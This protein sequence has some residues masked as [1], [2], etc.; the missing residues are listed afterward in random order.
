MNAP[1]LLIGAARSSSGKTTL[2]LGLMRALTRRG[3][4]VAPVKCGPDYID[5]AFHAAATGRPGVNLDSW[6]MDANL[7]A[8]LAARVSEGADIVIAEGAMGL[9]D[10][11]PGGAAG[12]GASADIA[13]LLGWSVVLVHDVSGQG[14]TA[15]A[16][17]RGIAGHDARVKVAGVVLNRVGSERHRRLAGEAIE[18]LDIPVFGALPRNEKMALPER[19]LGLVQ[20]GETPG[21]DDRLDALADFVEAHVD[22]EAIV[23]CG[24]IAASS[25]VIPDASRKRS[26]RESSVTPDAS[27]AAPDSRSPAAR[28][29]GMTGVVA[30]PPP[31]QRIAVARDDAFSFFYPHLA[32]SWRDAGA[33]L[34]FF[35]PLADEAPPEDCDLCWLPG[36]YPELHAG[37]L[38]AARGFK[39][40]LRR[41]AQRGWLHGECGGYMVLGRA[42]IDAA[43]AAHEMAGLLELETSFAKR[44]LHLG[45]RQARL[46][47]DHPLGAVGL[48]LRGHEFHYATVLREEGAPFALARDAYSEDERPAGLARNGVSGSFFHLLA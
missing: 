41:F 31:A 27:V 30:T 20:A 6:A 39:N 18:A 11:A 47:V 24:T 9:F 34:R 32:Q 2:T 38:S 42:L 8:R 46:A 4:R 10:G 15:A 40:G 17:V 29:S 3:L 36:G 12:I 16:I 7:I 48:R 25:N 1:G 28:A 43:G 23:A 26:D 37:R 13:A 5:P 44:K 21:L 14:Q 19:H 35:S 33:E 22:V 45:Y